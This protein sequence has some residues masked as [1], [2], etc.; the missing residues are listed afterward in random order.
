MLLVFKVKN[1]LTP[2]KTLQKLDRLHRYCDEMS[3]VTELYLQAL[4][5]NSNISTGEHLQDILYC[6]NHRLDHVELDRVFRD[7][8]FSSDIKV[9]WTLLTTVC[10][11]ESH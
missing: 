6:F 9:I 1:P 5:E 10:T 4:R 8:P 7:S 11:L 2:V 3:H